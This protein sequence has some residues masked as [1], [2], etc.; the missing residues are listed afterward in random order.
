MYV[1]FTIFVAFMAFDKLW[2]IYQTT[3]FLSDAVY[4][5]GY[6]VL[7]FYG[8]HFHPS[9]GIS[10]G[11]ISNFVGIPPLLFGDISLI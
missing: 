8:Y 11:D 4:L 9:K 3:W 7:T 2:F 10:G 1:I 6:I 5:S